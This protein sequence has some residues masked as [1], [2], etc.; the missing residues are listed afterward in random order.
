[1]KAM[2]NAHRLFDR[3]G[4]WSQF[5]KLCVVEGEEDEVAEPE[6]QAAAAEE[7]SQPISPLGCPPPPVGLPIAARPKAAPADGEDDAAASRWEADVRAMAWY[8]GMNLV[9]DEAHMGIAEEALTATVPDE[10]SEAMDPEGRAYYWRTEDPGA[11]AQ[12]EHPADASFRRRLLEARA[13][14]RTAE[15]L[16]AGLTVAEPPMP[17]MFRPKPG[18]ATV[19][20][21]AEYLGMDLTADRGLLWIADAALAAGMPEGWS[22]HETSSGPPFFHNAHFGITQWEHPT[23]QFFRSMYLREKV[24]LET[25]DRKSVV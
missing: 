20:E 7:Q 3:V 5:V 16:E 6:P 11:E 8:L 12:W 22:M 4:C 14:G 13:A 19:E 10:W 1:M 17:G 9:L 25:G 24:K 21:L 2:L 15:S 18:V 23:D